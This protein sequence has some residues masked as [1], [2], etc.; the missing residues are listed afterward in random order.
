MTGLTKIAVTEQH[1]REASSNADVAGS[2]GLRF[3]Q[4]M[5]LVL[6]IAL[7]VY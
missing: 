7:P 5:G 4:F 2:Q 3:S 1:E 6:L